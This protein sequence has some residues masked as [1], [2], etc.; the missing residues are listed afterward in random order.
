MANP[1]S[2]AAKAA[3]RA[4]WLKNLHQWHWIS[5]ACALLGI[6]V[7]SFTGITL[8]HSTQIEAKP[9]VRT[10]R[11][12]LPA[13]AL[14]PLRR[15]GEGHDGAKAPL[16]ADTAAWLAAAW[17]VRAAG[18]EAEWSAEDVYVAL[19]RPGGDAWVRIALADGRAEYE[20]T[21]RGWISWLNDL[22][23]GRNTGA[24]WSWFIDIFAGACLLFALTGLLILKFH[25]ANRSA[26][27]PVVGLGVL[28]PVLIAL[29]LI[30]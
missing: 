20:I 13:A 8:N 7:F 24:A 2:S 12:T 19:P 30:H 10:Q 21:D 14:A 18:K 4:R 9:Q 23:K 22:H 11:A 28:V 3:S 17:G 15:F 29:L 1:T 26:T 27:W 6:L 16:P 5:S 25:A